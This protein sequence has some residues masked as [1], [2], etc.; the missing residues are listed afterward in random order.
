[1]YFHRPQTP[2][3]S[4]PGPSPVNGSS[5]E[6]AVMLGEMRAEGRRHT[7]ILL[8]LQERLI[9]LPDKI[10]ER[11][12]APQPAPSQP[13]PNLGSI[14]DWVFAATALAALAAAIAGKLPWPELINLLRKLPAAS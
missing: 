1:M 12:P 9:D 3:P 7:E 2:P 6:H 14:R 13:P 5:F 10:A 4:W 8:S 11:M